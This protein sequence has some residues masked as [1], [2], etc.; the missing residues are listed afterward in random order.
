MTELEHSFADGRLFP[1]TFKGRV[2]LPA[3]DTAEMYIRNTY[4]IA[5]D[6]ERDAGMTWYFDA[7]DICIDWMK[8]YGAASHAHVAGII[9][10]LSPMKSWDENLRLAEEVVATGTTNGFGYAVEDAVKMYRGAHPD[11]ILFQP[12][13]NNTKVRNFYKNMSEPDSH[14]YVTIDRHMIGLLAGNPRATNVQPWI[15]PERHAW[16]AE[17]FQNVAVQ[18]G[19]IPNQLQ[20]ITWVVCRRKYGVGTDE[21]AQQLPLFETV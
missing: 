21:S 6:G 4:E 7:H 3:E 9:A 8:T 12:H 16:A 19:I 2:I 18:I 14:E 15:T 17:R 11:D 13:R 10:S 5:T 20:A 1:D